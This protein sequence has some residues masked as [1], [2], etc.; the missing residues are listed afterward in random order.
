MRATLDNELRA[1]LC[2]LPLGPVV[3]TQA[4]AGLQGSAI[5]DF[6]ERGFPW[7]DSPTSVSRLDDRFIGDIEIKGPRLVVLAI[8]RFLAEAHDHEADPLAGLLAHCV[9]FSHWRPI[10]RYRVC[11]R[12]APVGPTARHCRIERSAVVPSDPVVRALIGVVY[13]FGDRLIDRSKQVQATRRQTLG[14]S[15]LR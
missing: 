11:T 5:R 8:C 1:R 12:P 4:T 2:L 15:S 3:A 9:G 14:S 13:R 10:L 6:A 7:F